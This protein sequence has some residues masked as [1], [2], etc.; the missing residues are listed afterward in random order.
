[1][2]MSMGTKVMKKIMDR[3]EE[4]MLNISRFRAG[5]SLDS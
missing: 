2:I 4:V 1:M 3:A 5:S